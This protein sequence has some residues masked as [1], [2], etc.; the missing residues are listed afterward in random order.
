MN[1]LESGI[2]WSTASGSGV[3]VAWYR[4]GERPL[5]AAAG[6]GLQEIVL[7]GLP[8]S[9][10]CLLWQPHFPQRTCLHPLALH[11]F[12][13][14][15]FLRMRVSWMTGYYRRA[16]RSLTKNNC[17]RRGHPRRVDIQ[18][19]RDSER[20]SPDDLQTLDRTSTCFAAPRP[21]HGP[22]S[23]PLRLG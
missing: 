8:R 4:S 22:M 12:I 16:R 1:R 11:S 20:R 7:T 10:H 15:H 5:K 19:S 14:S 2:H 21:R 13:R 18:R 17:S 3:W 23:F 6:P 9:H